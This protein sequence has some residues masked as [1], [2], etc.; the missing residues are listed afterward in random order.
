[1]EGIAEEQL[2]P[3]GPGLDQNDAQRVQVQVR[4]H[5][6]E[7]SLCQIVMFQAVRS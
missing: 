2:P 3:V 1:M 6:A 7:L 4:H 5:A